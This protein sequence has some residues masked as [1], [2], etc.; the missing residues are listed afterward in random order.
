MACITETLGLSL[1]TCATTHARTEENNQ[2][3]FESGKQIIKLVEEDIKPSDI[4]TQEAFNNDKKVQVFIGQVIAA[5]TGLNLPAAATLIF[6]N[7]DWVAANNIQCESR[8]HRLTQTRDVEC[9]YMLFNDSISE[10]MFDKVIYKA[11]LMDE[12]IKSENQKQEK[13]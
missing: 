9:I 13:K 1:P 2:I 8:I 12:T 3:A 4:M 11:Y 6:N 7:Y 10:E 5:G